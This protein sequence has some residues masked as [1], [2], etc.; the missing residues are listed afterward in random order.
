MN[1]M[2]LLLIGLVVLLIITAAAA[3]R[4]EPLSD[5]VLGISLNSGSVSPFLVPLGLNATPEGAPLV[6]AGKEYSSG[7]ALPVPISLDVSVDGQYS[8]FSTLVGVQQA[9]GAPV[10][11]TIRALADGEVVFD[12]GPLAESDA[13]KSVTLSLAGVKLLKL[14]TFGG[15]GTAVF[16]NAEL[17]PTRASKRQAPVDVAR[18]ATVM[19]WDPARMDGVRVDRLTEFPAEDLYLA[20]EVLPKQGL[21]S[22][23]A[24]AEGKRCLGLEWATPRR[25]KRV[26]IVFPDAASMPDITR[27][28]LEAWVRK[29]TTGLSEYSLWQGKWEQLHAPLVADGTTWRAEIL[30]SLDPEV[31]AE[32]PEVPLGVRRRRA[33]A[34]EGLPRRDDLALGRGKNNSHL[35][36]QGQSAG[37]Q[38]QRRLSCGRAVA[39]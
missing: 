9:S 11:V 2:P 35:N 23:P 21:Y 24:Y 28:R 27:C 18:Y 3:G 7:V 19:T 10:P 37:G 5:R 26:G 4:P 39:R 29:S 31:S 8:R 38:L 22:A 15:G 32:V 20:T 30:S 12:S 1:A 17:E 36:R 16:A 34:G 6:I 33:S 25:L 13:P 14:V